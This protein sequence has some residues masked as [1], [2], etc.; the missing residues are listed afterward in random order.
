MLVA[1]DHFTKMAHA[2]KC[3][4]QSAKQVAR[5]LWDKYFCIYRFPQRIHADQ[6]ANF[7]SQLI[8]ELLQIAVVKKSRTT[9]YH[10]MGNG[11]TERF[12]RTLG[13]MIRALPPSDKQK[14]PQ[15]L[16][17]LTFT[18]NCTAHELTGYAPFNLMYGRIPRLPIDVM[19]HSVE[20][21]NDITDYH[22][23]VKRM[24]D[25]L[26]E[27]LTMAQVNASA[28]QQRQADLYNKRIKGTDIDEGDQVL[29]ANKGGRGRRKLADRWE[30]ILYTVV[31]KDLRC[32]TYY[33]R[34]PHTGQEKIVH[35]NL[36]LRANFLPVELD[37]ERESSFVSSSESGREGSEQRC[38]IQVLKV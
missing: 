17:T 12:N 26:K 34:H 3:S 1:T 19:F 24:R 9:P 21:D 14:W 35:R 25:D 22:S 33:I 4:D 38:T 8:Q 13:N 18:Y 29:V 37:H 5:Q 27:A 23:Y 11:H 10:P 31:S 28:G 30:S 15:M 6:G 16:Q 2:F 36:L 7:E 20:R 32:H